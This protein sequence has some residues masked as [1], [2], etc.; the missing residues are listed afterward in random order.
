[1]CT[2]GSIR[3]TG[4]LVGYG[5]SSGDATA[6]PQTIDQ[7]IK[8]LK[9]SSPWRRDLEQIYERFAKFKKPI[10]WPEPDSDLEDCVFAAAAVVFVE[11]TSS[12]RARD[13]LRDA[14]GGK[15]FEYL[16]APCLHQ[17]SALLDSSA[18]AGLEIEDDMRALMSEHRELVIG[19]LIILSMIR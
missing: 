17:S 10:D 9:T 12:E 18:P 5:H 19:L 8:L 1:V 13:L 4:F 3:R 2:R 14:L 7:T 11:P 15:R 6:N 16:L